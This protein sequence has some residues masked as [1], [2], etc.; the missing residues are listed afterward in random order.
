V[1]GD[2]WQRWVTVCLPSFDDRWIGPQELYDAFKGG[3]T[4][5]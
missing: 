4:S 5:S 3:L 1:F 2:A